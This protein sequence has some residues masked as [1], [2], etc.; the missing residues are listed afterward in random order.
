MKYAAV[1]TII[2]I[3]ALFGL[4]VQSGSAQ[5]KE[6]VSVAVTTVAVKETEHTR[7]DVLLLWNRNQRSTPIG[8]GIKACIKGGTGGILGGGIMSCTLNIILPL[9]KISSSGVIHNLARY[10][11]VLTGGTGVYEGVSGPLFVRRVGDGVRRLTF[12]A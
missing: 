12:R 7:T 6:N 1:S 5:Q 2:V 11:L 3:C 9:G 4:L 8:H 10:T